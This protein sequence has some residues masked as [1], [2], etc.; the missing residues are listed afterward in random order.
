MDWPALWLS[1]GLALSTVLLL[2]PVALA[3]G[4]WLAHGQSVARAPVAALVLLPLVPPPTVLGFYLLVAL[5][6][7]SALGRLWQAA[8]GGTLVFSFAGILLASIIANLPFAVQPAQRGFAAIAPSLRE[9][10]ALCGMAPWARFWRVELPLAWP[11][12]ASGLVLAFAH[13][14]GEFGVVLMVGGAIPGR[15]QTLALSIYDRVQVMDMAGAGTQAGVLL[16]ISFV[17][18]ATTFWLGR[19]RG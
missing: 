11:G 16:A 17:A 9:A 12:V 10:A 5:A 8:T 15:T 3:L 7:A 4:H 2:L 14:L 1:L 13:T 6:P 19:N 18:V